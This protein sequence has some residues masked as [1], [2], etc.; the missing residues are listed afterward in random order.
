M[1]VLV[2]CGLFQGSR[3]LQK[4]NRQAP[5]FDPS[6]LDAVIL[7]HAHMDHSGGLPRL[8][9]QGFRGPIYCSRGTA[10][11]LQIVLPD[12]ARL[13]E[14]EADHRNRH[15]LTRHDPALP[16]YT[17]QDA[18]NALDL[19]APVAN[20]PIDAAPGI[21]SQFYNSG[22][23]L[24]SR[25]AL[26]EI[27]GADQGGQGGRILFSGDLGR[28]DH[29]ILRDPAKPVACDTLLVESTYG[30]H[31][32]DALDTKEALARIIIQ[33][34]ERR[35]PLL[36]PAFAVARTQELI[37]QIRQLEDEGRIPILPVSIDSPMAA[38]VTQAYARMLNDYGD[39]YEELR[40]AKRDPLSTR[41]MTIASSRDDSKKLNGASGARIVITASGMMTGGRVMHHAQRILPDKNATILFA[42]FQA[43]GTTGRYILDGEPEVKIFKRW[44]PVRCRVE[45]IE[46]FSAH[47]DWS[48]IL[49]WLADMP[50]TPRQVFVTHGEPASATALQERIVRRFGW[51][52]NVPRHGD[53]VEL[54]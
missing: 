38:A 16:L 46:G 12:G 35:G 4:R 30:D 14:E 41:S 6:N 40:S 8:A 27:D 32:H 34:S 24:G 28:F 31:L 44:V 52:V 48:E 39:D 9:A 33:T 22:H 29:T 11:L 15:G 3:E 51:K 17:E 26:V 18:R 19:L 25:F 20:L 37:S 42:G 10:A 50:A 36:I 23:I 1:K 21:K 54:L 53:Q 13:Q 47:A 7:T 43:V 5:P 45:R 2:D 49:R